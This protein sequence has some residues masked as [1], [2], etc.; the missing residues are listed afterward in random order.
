MDNRE[1]L[2]DAIT[3]EDGTGYKATVMTQYR[4][5]VAEFKKDLADAILDCLRF[6]V[7][8]RGVV[9]WRNPTAEG[10]S[11][12]VKRQKYGKCYWELELVD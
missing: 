3:E 12:V 11:A 9:C 1:R 6:D 4:E 2:I 10:K 8:T 7:P 5:A